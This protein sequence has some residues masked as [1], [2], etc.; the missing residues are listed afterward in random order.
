MDAHALMLV[1]KRK[2]GGREEGKKEGKKSSI[3]RFRGFLGIRIP[4]ER[5]LVGG[6]LWG[7]TE[8]D[9]TEVT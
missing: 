5:S 4:K 8:L 9:T 3:S 2:K 6:R 1:K 7:L